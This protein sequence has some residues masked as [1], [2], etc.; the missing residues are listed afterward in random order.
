MRLL[1]FDA[2]VIREYSLFLQ[3]SKLNQV[4]FSSRGN[5]H[6]Y[7]KHI[8]QIQVVLWSVTTLGNERENLLPF[9]QIAH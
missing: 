3:V 6:V 7:S 9:Y 4:L 2:K 5:V 1:I 8:R